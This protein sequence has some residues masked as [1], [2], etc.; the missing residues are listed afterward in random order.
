MGDLQGTD[1]LLAA[2]ERYRTLLEINNAIVSKLTK[3]GL[4]RAICV[5]MRRV[6]PY[7]RS[8]IF[9]FDEDKNVLRL[10][11]IESSV[12]S[13]SFVVGLEMDPERSHAGWPFR[14]GRTLL[15]RNLETEREFDSEEKLFS[16]GFRSMVSVPLMVQG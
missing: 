15:R 3:E 5:V 1:G 16:E 6:M 4:F 10:F 8:A 9:L 12:S 7:D 14:H 13:S 2:A 11:A